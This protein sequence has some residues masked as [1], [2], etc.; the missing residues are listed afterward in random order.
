[1][2]KIIDLMAITGFL[3]SGSMTAA[4]VISYFQ[5]NRFMD[6]SM[7]RIGGQITEHVEAELESKIKGAMPQLPKATGP[8]LPF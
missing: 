7:E 2:R 4:L 5:F 8:A 6:E 3:L 1:M